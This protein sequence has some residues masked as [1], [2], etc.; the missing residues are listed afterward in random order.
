MRVIVK[1]SSTHL[2]AAGS[3]SRYVSDRDRNPERETAATRTLF[4]PEEDAVKWRAAD[5]YLSGKAGAKPSTRNLRH[6]ILSFAKD[7]A[8]GLEGYDPADRD[9]PYRIV[10]RHTLERISERLNITGAKWVAGVHR[11]TKHTHIHI[12]LHKEAKDA[13][14]GERVRVTSFPK[15]MLNDRD[16]TTG[17]SVPGLI[18]RDASEAI[19]SLLQRHRANDAEERVPTTA[20]DLSTPKGEMAQTLSTRH[21]SRHA[22]IKEA[23]PR[24]GPNEHDDGTT[25]E[26]TAASATEYAATASASEAARPSRAAAL[27][28]FLFTPEPTQPSPGPTQQ[29]RHNPDVST[30]ADPTP[31]Q[32]LS[33]TADSPAQFMSNPDPADPARKVNSDQSEPI[34]ELTYSDHLRPA[35]PLTSRAHEDQPYSDG[36]PYA[37]QAEPS[38]EPDLDDSADFGR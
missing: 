30:P 34:G 4:T 22:T 14:T 15:E 21:E 7:D 25:P 16:Q 37:P 20:Q 24:R 8:Q 36:T 35:S 13:T 33:K 2:G 28:A 11:H 9:R 10:A 32:S 1:I 12:L 29:A 18:N 31:A 6:I 5:G 26:I 23:A 3:G 17:K 27:L 19:D 38:R